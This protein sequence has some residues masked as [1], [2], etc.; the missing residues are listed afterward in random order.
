MYIAFDT[1][2]FLITVGNIAPQLVCLTLASDVSNGPPLIYDHL[3]GPKHFRTL[4]EIE[5]A[6]LIGHNV[7]FDLGVLVTQDP[8]LMPLI[9]KALDEGRI[10][11]TAIREKLLNLELGQLKFSAESKMQK[12]SLSSLVEKYLYLDISESKK[13]DAWR[14][15]YSELYEVPLFAWPHDATEYALNDAK[16]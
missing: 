4:L 10:H 1:E 14:T 8:T 5:E 11:D 16:S 9:F 13:E 3:E 7:V 2:T 15:R 12:Y 6:H